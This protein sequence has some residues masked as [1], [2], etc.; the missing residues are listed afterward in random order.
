[1]SS[2][3]GHL[4]CIPDMLLMAITESLRG[5]EVASEK[6]PVIGV[7]RLCEFRGEYGDSCLSNIKKSFEK[8]LI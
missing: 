1:M 4:Q 5:V 7:D 2:K 3:C 6:V 8:W